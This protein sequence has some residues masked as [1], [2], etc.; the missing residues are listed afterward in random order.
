MHRIHLCLGVFSISLV[1][2]LTG[3]DTSLTET[4][5]EDPAVTAEDEG[6]KFRHAHL[7]DRAVRLSESADRARL[8]SSFDEEA[9]G[10]IVGLDTYR[11]FSRYGEMDPYRIFSR[12]SE[13]DPYRIFSRY[14]YDHVFDGLALWVD[15]TMVHDLIAAME[16]DDEIAWIEP[17]IQVKLTPLG[18]TMMAPELVET[19]P[20][21]V[22]RIGGGTTEASNVDL[23]VVDTGVEAQ[24][25]DLASSFDVTAGRTDGGVDQDGHGTHVAGTAAALSN[26]TGVRGVAPGAQ[27]HSL[28]VLTGHE[29][30]DE[31]EPVDL[32]KAI[33]AMERVIGHKLGHPQ[34]PVVVN[35]SLGA[36]IGTT[37][38][39]ALDEAVVSAIDN[40]IVV[41]V[42]AGNEGTDASTITPAHVEEAI[43]VGAYDPSDRFAGFSNYG[44]H[45]DILAP[46][47]DILSVKPGEGLNVL[48]GTSMAAA[49]V[50][51]A[52]AAFLAE[53]PNASPAQVRE[54]LVR[55]G[56]AGISGVPTGTTDRTVFLGGSS[57]EGPAGGLLNEDVPP[58]FQYAVVAGGD[59]RLRD[60]AVVRLAD[61]APARA[62]ASLYANDD[63]EL[64]STDV[65]VEGF[66]YA[67]DD[68]K[69]HTATLAPRLNPTGLAPAQRVAPL[70]L[71]DL[72]MRDYQALATHATTGYLNVFGTYQLGT[73]THP[74]IWYV[75]GD[76]IITEP[77]Q[78]SGHGIFLVRGDVRIENDVQVAEGSALALFAEGDVRLTT[79]DLDVEALIYA[80]GQVQVRSNVTVTGSITSLSTVFLEDDVKLYYRPVPPALTEPFWPTGPAARPGTYAN[81]VRVIWGS[82]DVEEGADTNVNRSSPDLD[83]GSYSNG[84]ATTVGVRFR[85]SSIPQGATIQRAYIQFVTHDESQGASELTIRA[86]DAGDADTFANRDESVS[87]RPVTSQAVTWTV[88]AW[89]TVGEAG[90]AQR[91]PDLSALVQALVD[92]SDW[93]GDDLAFIIT[94][95][96][97]REARS[98]EANPEQAPTL[99]VEWT[100]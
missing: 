70:D 66:A 80:R 74:Y 6:P 94:G 24:D 76:L 4:P 12:Y 37:A 35:F 88:P 5:I 10:I 71:P 9:V 75:E 59:I 100:R 25:L 63:V 82:D 34:T 42:A 38:Y 84:T 56:Q 33:A 54:A 20:W 91:T 92:R 55:S 28:R 14:E 95:T 79:P 15:E 72:N 73:S 46:G 13:M 68:V 21:G 52:V 89:N 83:L 30:K 81:T 48:S 41:V 61:G 49:H 97:Q 32:S 16:Q 3:C 78:I 51:G 93:A 67:V 1:L 36:D 87:E 90:A 65:R 23:F 45:V 53:E 11:I 2:L 43:T 44:R 22:L 85:E 39:N 69:G 98:S 96:G 99:H 27:I 62:N 31:S 19:T 8:L 57:A 26:G 40:G 77:T 17:D 47:V 50:S 29:R 18:A 60:R 64:R 86:Q 7:M 58:F